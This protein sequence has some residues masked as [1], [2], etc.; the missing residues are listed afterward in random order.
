M[1]EHGIMLGYENDFSSYRILKLESRKI[2]QVR[3]FKFYE[4][5]FPG[6]QEQLAHSDFFNVGRKEMTNSTP[7]PNNIYNIID[8]VIESSP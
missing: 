2:V 1:A 3:N 8:P 7:S 6:L 4:Y 5:I